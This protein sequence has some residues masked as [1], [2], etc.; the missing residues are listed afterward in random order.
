MKPHN[1]VYNSMRQGQIW[2]Y[3][4]HNDRMFHK[5]IILKK[6]EKE[7]KVSLSVRI[8]ILSSTSQMYRKKKLMKFFIND[9]NYRNY[10]R[11]K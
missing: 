2:L 5:F 7:N 10:K 9:I 11:I 6:E 3:S 8:F 1:K 4:L